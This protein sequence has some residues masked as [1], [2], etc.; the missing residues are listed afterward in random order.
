M[1]ASDAMN[2]ATIRRA[3]KYGRRHLLTI[4]EDMGTGGGY[5][6]RSRNDILL[7]I[8]MLRE[9]PAAFE[10]LRTF[11]AYFAAA[12]GG[13]RSRRPARHRIERAMRLAEGA[14]KH[15]LDPL[16]GRKG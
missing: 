2:T 9:A 14:L 1:D 16:E 11:H 10:A 7:A 15:G 12:P 5:S 6:L 3:A 8:A 13:T 4:F